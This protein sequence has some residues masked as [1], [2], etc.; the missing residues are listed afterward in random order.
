MEGQT[1]LLKKGDSYLYNLRNIAVHFLGDRL[2]RPLR[3]N[4]DKR[5]DRQL[6]KTMADRPKGKLVPVD[7]RKNLSIK[8]FKARYA[9]KQPVVFAGEALEWPCC[10]HWSQ[11]SFAERFGGDDVLLFNPVKNVD[12]QLEYEFSTL[13]E[14]IRKMQ[15]DPEINVRFSPLLT[16]HPELKKDLDLHW[17]RQ[18]TSLP[19]PRSNQLQLFIAGKKSSTHIHTAISENLFLQ[20]EGRKHWVIY[21]PEYNPVFKVHIDRTPYFISDLVHDRPDPEKFPHFDKAV[22]YE[23]TLQPGDILYN[24]NFFWHFVT[25]LE[26]SVSLGYRWIDP[27]AI[28]KQDPTL[29]FLTFCSFYPP[30]W[31]VSQLKDDF[32]KILTDK[33]NKRAAEKRSGI[34]I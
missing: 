22:G 13:G 20:V 21:P 26:P 5:I 2:S 28:W 32:T 8:E 25:S 24:P 6:Q 7:R 30:L 12:G 17:Y 10:Q 4:V 15:K 9:R 27:G 29:G 18:R 31:K 16:L 1:P 11:A 33:R 3:E 34:K 19:L 23:C 14:A